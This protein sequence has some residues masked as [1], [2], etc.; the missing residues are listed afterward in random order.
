[1]HR[2]HRRI[3]ASALVLAL[4]LSAS[5]AAVAQKTTITFGVPWGL[6]VFEGVLLELVDAYN[7]QSE[8]VQVEI[9]SGW[10]ANKLITAAAGMAP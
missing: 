8:T 9:E 4:A 5:A 2:H 3:L 10:N 7:A 6:D 1:M